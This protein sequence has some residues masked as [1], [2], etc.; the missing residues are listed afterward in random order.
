M[1]L[2]VGAFSGCGAEMTGFQLVKRMED[3][4]A[5]FGYFLSMVGVAW[6]VMVLGG[7]WAAVPWRV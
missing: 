5:G 1:S 2:F 4:S 3:I 6:K 7:V